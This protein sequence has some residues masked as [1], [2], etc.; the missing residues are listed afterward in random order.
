[1]TAVPRNRGG[2]TF[3]AADRGLTPHWQDFVEGQVV[4]LAGEIGPRYTILGFR[5][6]D[7]A[8]LYPTG[9]NASGGQ[10]TVKAELL[11]KVRK[12]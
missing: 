9:T 12:P 10:R 5:P 11:R 4:R 1:M 7:L 3:T 2:R 8:E 6:G